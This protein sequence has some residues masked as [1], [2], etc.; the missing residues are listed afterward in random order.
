MDT[1]KVA[2]C[3]RCEKLQPIACL[4]HTLE[5]VSPVGGEVL[6]CDDCFRQMRADSERARSV[7]L[8]RE[9]GR[10]SRELAQE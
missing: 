3:A 9:A 8:I 1:F 5:L 10:R 2:Y 4:P 7:V 6:C